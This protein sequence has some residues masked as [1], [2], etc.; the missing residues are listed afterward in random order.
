MKTSNRALLLFTA[1]LFCIITSCSS[2]DNVKDWWWSHTVTP[3]AKA[4]L[5]TLKPGMKRSEIPKCFHM[6]D[7]MFSPLS[8]HYCFTNDDIDIM[9]LIEFRP[10]GM[11]DATYSDRNKWPKW[12]QEH[13]KPKRKGWDDILPPDNVIVSIGKLEPALHPID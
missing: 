7:S 10:S 2:V 4:L 5:A 3:K 1:S 8:E 12:Y 9:V 6:C 11:D 13:P